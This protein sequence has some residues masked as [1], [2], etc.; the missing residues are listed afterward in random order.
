MTREQYEGTVTVQLCSPYHRAK[1]LV[2]ET[3]TIHRNVPVTITDVTEVDERLCKLECTP[4]TE[5]IK[6]KGDRL[7]LAKEIQ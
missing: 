3:W 6:T 5:V 1:Q 7:I 2:G 4:Q